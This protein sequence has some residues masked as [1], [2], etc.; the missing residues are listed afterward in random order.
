[1]QKLSWTRKLGVGEVGSLAGREL[2]LSRQ[3][4]SYL[5]YRS[6]LVPILQMKNLRL[7]E[8]TTSH[9]SRRI[10]LLWMPSQS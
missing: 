9:I 5:V 8:A 10:L 1:M 3:D 2:P 4:R 7:R 6:Y